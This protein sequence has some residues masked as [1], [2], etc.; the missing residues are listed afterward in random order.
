MDD[1]MI[2]A[3]KQLC[4]LAIMLFAM[5]P[6]QHARAAG[7]AA[8]TIIQNTANVEYTTPS[9]A[10]VSDTS[11]TATLRV[12]EVLD[13]TV[14]RSGAN[15]ITVSPNSTGQALAF[16]VTNNGNGQEAFRLSTNLLVSG[17]QFDPSN[18][19]LAIDT[20]G[21]GQYD[22]SIDQPYVAGQNDPLLNPD[23][24]VT[25]FILS[26]IPASLQN[27]NRGLAELSAQAV[28]GT[29]AP[30]FSFA[31]MGNGGGDAVVGATRARATDTSAYVA[32]LVNTQFIKTQSIIDPQGGNTTVPGSIITYTLTTQVSGSGT[33][34]GAAVI[35]PIPAQTSYI[36]GSMRLNGAPLSDTP[37]SDSGQ[38]TANGIQVNLGTLVAPATQTVTF[39]VKLN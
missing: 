15:D 20:N 4:L 30:G 5:W 22:P 7:V 37:D 21:N 17:D 13:V 29:G 28:T 23:T 16:T 14:S 12:D 8:G 38:L 11:N 31:G 2:Y 1:G 27:S 9:G 6:T 33:L 25:V 35:D 24:S 36:A 19:R 10:T 18:G 34:S 26:D 32:T 39:Q 3:L